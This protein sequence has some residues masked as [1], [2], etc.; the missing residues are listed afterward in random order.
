MIPEFVALSGEWK[1]LDGMRL[2]E[3]FVIAR[4]P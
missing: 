2:I 4:W 3:E 1:K